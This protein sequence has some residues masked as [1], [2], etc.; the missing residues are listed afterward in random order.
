[1]P[2][3]ARPVRPDAGSS[4]GSSGSNGGSSS[5]PTGSAT[6]PS[7]GGSSTGASE[8]D[9]HLTIVQTSTITGI[10]PGLEPAQIT[11]RVTNDGAASTYV[12]TVTVRVAGITVAR[13]GTC[14]ATDFD[15]LDGTM[16]VGRTLAPGESADFTGARISFHDKVT[17]QDACQAAVVNLGYASS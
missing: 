4:N 14:D 11:G 13:P 7:P 3:P 10:A 6:S 5:A 8:N 2:A 1:M 16:P 9:P 15:L 12:T 17:N